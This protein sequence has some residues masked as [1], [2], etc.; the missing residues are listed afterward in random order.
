M[1]NNNPDGQKG[2]QLFFGITSVATTI[3]A[4]LITISINK[5]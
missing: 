3:A 4:L 1:L 5:K 2:W